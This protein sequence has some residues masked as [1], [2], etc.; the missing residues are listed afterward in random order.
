MENEQLLPPPL[1]HWLSGLGSLLLGQEISLAIK[2][3]KKN[4]ERHLRLAA[5][6]LGAEI[7]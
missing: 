7:A 2:Q 6:G 4:L 3:P 5:A 1:P